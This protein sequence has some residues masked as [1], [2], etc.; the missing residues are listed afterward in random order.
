M[1]KKYTMYFNNIKIDVVEVKNDENH[2]VQIS[3]LG[4]PLFNKKPFG[5]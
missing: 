4:D 2:L 3:V 1:K 5:D